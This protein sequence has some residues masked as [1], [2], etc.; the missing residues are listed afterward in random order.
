MAL[1]G[2]EFVVEVSRDG[3]MLPPSLPRLSVTL[4]LTK[5]PE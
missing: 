2:D 4:F 1:D 3:L 5:V